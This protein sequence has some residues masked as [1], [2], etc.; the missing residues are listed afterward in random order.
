MSI[1]R[2]IAAQVLALVC[3][4]M[5]LGAAAQ[6]YPTKTITIVVPFSPGGAVDIIPRTMAPG[7]SKALGVPII[8]EN[9]PGAAGNLGAAYVSRADPDGHTL[10]LFHSALF[11]VNPWLFDKLPFNA[12]EDLRPISD[13]ATLPNVLVV[14]A[15]LPAK[16]IAELVALV[17]ANP[18]KYNYGTPGVGTSSHLCMEFFRLRAGTGF[19]VVHIPFTSGPAAVTSLISNQVQMGCV[20][21]NATLA[22]VK[23]NRLRPLAVTTRSR[24][25]QMPEVPTMDEAGYKDFEVTLWFG[26]AAPSRTPDAVVRALNA[27][28]LKSLKDPEVVKRFGAVGMS[29]LGSSPQDVLRT[30]A[31]ESETWRGVIQSANVRLEK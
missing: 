26:L 24:S 13:L 8:V 16:N 28:V 23:A 17:K 7:L 10:L 29:T 15:G 4:C 30:M 25:T 12:K 1:A 11:T 6:S 20:A 5:S 21:V 9:K 14:N 2:V 22:H 3:G 18:N 31:A 27:E 19:D